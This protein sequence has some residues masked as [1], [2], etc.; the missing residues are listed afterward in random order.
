MVHVSEHQCWWTNAPV[1]DSHHFITHTRRRARVQARFRGRS[2]NS[3]QKYTSEDQTQL[4]SPLQNLASPRKIT[5]HTHH[6][7]SVQQGAHAKRAHAC[8]HKVSC[9]PLVNFRQNRLFSPPITNTR[10]CMGF[11]DVYKMAP[12][13]SRRVYSLRIC[14]GKK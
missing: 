9:G 4:A 10:M 13:N 2:I 3:R 1:H 11:A 7:D 12:N 14:T 6:K 5:P 8:M